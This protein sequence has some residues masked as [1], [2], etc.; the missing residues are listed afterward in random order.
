M[1]VT[2][3]KTRTSCPIFQN[4]RPSMVIMV[5]N[6]YN[7][8]G[9]GR[10][11]KEPPWMSVL[12]MGGRRKEGGGWRRKESFVLNKYHCRLKPTTNPVI[13]SISHCQPKPLADRDVYHCRLVA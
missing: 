11:I 8:G 7:N 3:L 9:R 12:G 2:N 6:G 1:L 10:E 4:P 13:G 5:K